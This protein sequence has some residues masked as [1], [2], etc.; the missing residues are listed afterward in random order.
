MSATST[1]NLNSL[2]LDWLLILGR[3]HFERVLRVFV[4]HYSGHRP[5]RGTQPQAAKRATAGSPIC[6]RAAARQ[7]PAAETASA[8]SSA[9]HRLAVREPTSRTPHAHSVCGAAYGKALIQECERSF[10]TTGY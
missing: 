5:R 9:E 4:N 7:H 3:G 10:G 6:E 2:T 8:D 1:S